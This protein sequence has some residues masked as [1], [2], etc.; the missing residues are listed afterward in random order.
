MTTRSDSGMTDERAQEIALR[1]VKA[2]MRKGGISGTFLRDIG[3]EAKD[4]GITTE[5]ARAFV[6]HL[7]P[8]VLADIFG[9]YRAS[10]TFGEPKKTFVV[11]SDD[12]R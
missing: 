1:I 12:A 7:L 8:E 6:E 5:E 11:H 9:Y 2:K 3:N 10:L 4:I